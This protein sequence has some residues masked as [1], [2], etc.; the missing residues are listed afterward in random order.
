MSSAS[1]KS[2]IFYFNDFGLQLIKTIQH[3]K[4]LEYFLRSIK[5]GFMIQKCPTSENYANLCPQ[6]L[7]GASLSQIT[8]PVQRDMEVIGLCYCSDV[9]EDQVAFIAPSS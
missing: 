8:A 2:F 5:K 4:I 3:L 6:Y 1:Q 7:V 9:I